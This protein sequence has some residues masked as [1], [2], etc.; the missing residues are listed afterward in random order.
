MQR[1]SV[2]ASELLRGTY[3]AVK[4]KSALLWLVSSAASRAV[5][6]PGVRLRT[7]GIVELRPPEIGA[8]AGLGSSASPVKLP[9]DT[10]SITSQQ[11]APPDA[12]VVRMLPRL[13]SPVKL[14]S[15]EPG[16]APSPIRIRLWFCPFA[17]F[18]G[19]VSEV[20]AVP[21]AS[22]NFK[23][24]PPTRFCPSPHICSSMKAPLGVAPR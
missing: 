14:K 17:T 1:T 22:K 15:G 16:A 18:V 21:G 10:Q 2:G 24:W 20:V 4:A 7:L 19:R 9:Q 3:P 13:C 12:Q 8:P 23:L 6:Q 5:A 11:T